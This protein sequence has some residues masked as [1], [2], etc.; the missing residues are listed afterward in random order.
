MT[1]SV[2]PRS[3]AT[4]NPTLVRKGFLAALGM[5]YPSCHSEERRD[6]ESRYEMRSLAPL[7]MIRVTRDDKE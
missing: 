1:L 7:G 3:E 6:D 2:I 4:R 5:T